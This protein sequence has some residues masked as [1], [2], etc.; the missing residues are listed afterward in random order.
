MGYATLC[1]RRIKRSHELSRRRFRAILR[2]RQTGLA[3]EALEDRTL[4][5]FNGVLQNLETKVIDAV[6]TSIPVIGSQLASFGPLKDLFN[7]FV[8]PL[9]SAVSNATSKDALEAAVDSALGNLIQ[10]PAVVTGN[11]PYDVSTDLHKDV[12]LLQVGGASKAASFGLGSF[13]DF[14]VTDNLNVTLHF[15]YRLNFTVDSN[16]S[17]SLD[18]SPSFPMTVNLV[19]TLPGFNAT[20]GT[21]NDLLAASATVPQG[22]AVPNFNVTFAINPLASGGVTTQLSGNAEATL[23]LALSFAPDAP[24]NPKLGATLHVAWTDDGTN[25]VGNF[26][27]LSISDVGLDIGT[28][29]PGFLTGIIGDIQ[30]FTKPL[31][32]IADALSAEVP[33]LKDIGVHLS[34]RSLAD[35]DGDPQVGQAV[36]LINLINHLPSADQGS[37][38]LLTFGGSIQFD[39]EP[40]S[41]IL[42]GGSGTNL[43]GSIT[44]TL[45]HA[46]DL[47]NQANSMS[48]DAAGDGFFSEADASS[49]ADFGFQF[50]IVTD[51]VR[52]I[53]PLL[54][55]QDVT[56]I[57]FQA[58]ASAGLHGTVGAQ[59]GP[60]SVF[61]TGGIDVGLNLSLGYDTHGLRN[62][63]KDGTLGDLADGL[64]FDTAK[65][66]I[67]I[68]GNIGVGAAALVVAVEGDLS[69]TASLTLDPTKVTNPDD[70]D[71]WRTTSCTSAVW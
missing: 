34:L 50:P 17:A 52:T 56:L 8:G 13:L 47:L 4:L 57:S 63:V 46:A 38:G 45:D 66:A 25:P 40:L 68:S 55:G 65:T 1:A 22:A 11:G 44:D 5:T 70:A 23:A 61:L 48:E 33:G 62:F 20:G 30:K 6:G 18:S 69:A 32:P 16:G 3:F 71:A 64:Y 21:L 35:L 60:F 7:Q 29:L 27:D 43:I 49:S 59:F 12:T 24:I 39:S 54:E 67:T 41:K 28:L 9:D 19:A 31:Q 37:G 14:K 15:D 26:T 2:T 58:S 10:T 36:D 51:P 42:G 53:F